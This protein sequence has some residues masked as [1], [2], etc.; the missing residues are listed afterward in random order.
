MAT[1]RDNI[2]SQPGE[3]TVRT[4]TERDHPAMRE[5]WNWAVEHTTANFWTQPQSPDSWDRRWQQ[6]H[7][8]FPSAVAERGANLVG[9]ALAAPFLEGCGTGDVAEVSVYV[10]RDHVATG[11]GKLLYEAFIPA[12]G[13][14]G[15]RML[16]AMIALPNP[17][18]EQLH[19]RFGFVRV[20]CLPGLGSK[21]GRVYD[22]AIW[23]RTLQGNIQD[24]ACDLH[25]APTERGT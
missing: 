11:V 20:G 25:P 13:S 9:F 10:H 22:V 15:L 1:D 2:T 6:R 3:T 5:I 4:A 8:A 7:A 19:K 18:C 17:A 14:R 21:F 16:V 23:Q 24:G 12:L